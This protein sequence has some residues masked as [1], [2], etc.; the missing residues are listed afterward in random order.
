MDPAITMSDVPHALRSLRDAYDS[1]KTKSKQWRLEQLSALKSMVTHGM[2]QLAAAIKEDLGRSAFESFVMEL[3]MIVAEVTYMQ[4]FLDDLMEPKAVDTD[5]INLPGWSRIYNDPYGVVMIMSPWNYPVNLLLI[6]LAGA[7]AAGNC[8]ML[9][10]ANYTKNTSETLVK[11]VREYLDPQ[12]IKIAVGDRHITTALLAERWDIIFFTGGKVV[13]KLVAE[14]A[15]KHLTPTILE[16]GGKS[17]VIVHEDADLAVAARRLCWA[18]FANAGQT[19][20]RPDYLMVH[21]K[22]ADKFVLKLKSTMRDFYGADPQKSEWF[23]RIIDDKAHARLC[24]LLERDKN[25]IIEGGEVDAQKRYISPTLADYGTDLNTFLASGLMEEE[26]F[27]PILPIF[28]YSSVQQALDVVNNGEKPLALY[29]FTTS[30]TVY[31]T[32]LDNTSSGSAMVNDCMMFMSNHN[33]PFG[34]VGESG[35][36]SYHGKA[37]FQAFS[38]QKSVLIKTNML[39]LRFRYPPYNAT[40][41]KLAKMFLL[42]LP[43]GKIKKTVHVLGFMFRVIGAFWLI[44]YGPEFLAAIRKLL[45]AIE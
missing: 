26:N 38:H 3:N 24:K 6:P 5:P 44:R 40:R 1:G 14:A 37:S 21:Q 34:G 35:M 22:I 23:A 20:I 25:Y 9:R 11:L 13:G 32:V 28:R 10:P 7:I 42:P 16:L 15:A 39:D 18:T 45:F 31:A 29:V 4:E 41:Q 30:K 27:G 19:C 17:P 8:V 33:L 36:G 43:F 12:C 2:D